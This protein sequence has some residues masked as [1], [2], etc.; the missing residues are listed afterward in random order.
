MSRSTIATVLVG[1]F[2]VALVVAILL[3]WTEPTP[4]V[5]LAARSGTV[6]GRILAWFVAP[7]IIPLLIWAV[8]RFRAA[9]ARPPI[10]LWGIIG[11]VVIFLTYVGE[12]ASRKERFEA[13]FPT[14]GLSPKARAEFVNGTTTA[15]VSRQTAS[16]L[17]K[18]AKVTAHQINAYC[19]CYAESLL[20]L[21]TVPE[22]R[23]VAE[24]GT[25]PTGF[26]TKVQQAASKC[27]P[28]AKQAPNDDE[29]EDVK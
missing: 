6:I 19:K 14:T 20:V 2:A 15:C 17:N 25:M 5:S 22:L 16:A 8:F 26:E 7:G 27:F 10:V 23:Y 28:T 9:K 1:Y 4:Y 18:E 21:M 11:A 3:E 29:W 24:H 13:A 12:M